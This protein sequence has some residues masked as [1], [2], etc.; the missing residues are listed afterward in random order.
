MLA[1]RPKEDLAP[2]VRE[3]VS[4]PPWDEWNL[5]RI[6]REE[7]RRMSWIASSV[8]AVLLV[9]SH[10]GYRVSRAVPDS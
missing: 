6:Q 5:P 7:T 3:W 2:H 10:A 1:D 9:V 8:T 4:T